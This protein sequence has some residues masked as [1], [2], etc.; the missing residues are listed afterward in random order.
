MKIERTA[1]FKRNF[2]ALKK[3]NYDMSKFENVLN[4]LVNAD[5]EILK[6]K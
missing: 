5:K 2:K 4:Y 3:K 1:T 6:N